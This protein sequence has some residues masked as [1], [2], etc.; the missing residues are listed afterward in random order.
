VGIRIFTVWIIMV[1]V[2]RIGVRF[3]IRV[4]LRIRVRHPIPPMVVLRFFFELKVDTAL[5]GSRMENDQLSLQLVVL[6][7][8]CVQFQDS[9]VGELR[10]LS[11][12]VEE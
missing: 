7:F 8:L 1:K 12:R 3:R 6:I 9:K 10:G 5:L 2:H 4:T 11:E